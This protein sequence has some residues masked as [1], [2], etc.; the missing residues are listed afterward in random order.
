MPSHRKIVTT[1]VFNT[2][3]AGQDLILT[4]QLQCFKAVSNK[5]TAMNCITQLNRRLKLNKMEEEL[6]N[7]VCQ[8]L[9]IFSDAIVIR[10]IS[11]RLVLL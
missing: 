5:K 4:F 9:P 8:Y 1:L 6:F 2:L 11:Q 3:H 10:T 7:Y